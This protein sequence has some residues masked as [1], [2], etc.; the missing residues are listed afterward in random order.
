MYLFILAVV[1]A[2]MCDFSLCAIFLSASHLVTFKREVRWC[3]YTNVYL[4]VHTAMADWALIST[5]DI[6]S[7][8]GHFLAVARMVWTVAATVLYDELLVYL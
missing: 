1:P 5:Q 6:L 3:I 8:A 7:D 4:P 2:A